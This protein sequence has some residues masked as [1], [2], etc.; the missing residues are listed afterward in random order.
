MPKKVKGSAKQDRKGIAAVQNIV[1]GDLEWIF[2]EQPTDDFGIDAQ[3][4]IVENEVA[5]GR[6]IATQIKS[7]PSY[8]KKVTTE[9]WWFNLDRDDLEYWLEHALPVVVILCDPATGVAHWE[10]VTPDKVVTGKR[11]GKKILI[12]NSKQLGDSS[13]AALTTV[14]EGKPYEL[15]IRKLR[16]ALPWMKLLQSGRRILLEADEWVNKTSGR[17]DLQV[18]SV[19]EANEDRQELG[20]WYLMAGL[21]RYEEVLPSLVPWA[22]AVLH[23]ETYDE[24]DVEDWE[25][26]CVRWDKEGDYFESE[27]YEDWY[28]KFDEVGLRPYANSAGEVDHWRLELVLNYLGKGF[29]AVDEFAE[30]DTWILTPSS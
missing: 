4:E 3:I 12:P 19:D 5:T 18:V 1:V 7:G 17:G 6:L 8:F 11:G 25:S 9:G 20:T 13:R 30:H 29:L 28:T 15:R 26:E 22:D 14:G 2:R 24:H 16:L 23:Q 21:Q 27:P 10:V